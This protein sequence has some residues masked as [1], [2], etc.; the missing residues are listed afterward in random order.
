M[1]QFLLIPL[2]CVSTLMVAADIHVSPSGND[3]NDGSAGSP[4]KTIQAAA[5]KAQPGDTVTVH[6]GTYREEINPPHGGV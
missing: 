5:N 4:L 3:E 6:A 1:L 2:L